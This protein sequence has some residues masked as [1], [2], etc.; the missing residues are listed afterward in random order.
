MKRCLVCGRATCDDL[1]DFGRQPVCH[2]FV[3]TRHEESFYPMALG[4][5]SHCATVQSVQ[6]IPPE[7]LVPHFDW[8]SYN[9]P[10]AH[11]DL[12]VETLCSLPGITNDSTVGGLSYKEDSTLRRFRDRGTQKT[13][14]LDPAADLAIKNPRA[15]IELIQNRIDNLF[16][17]RMRQK[18][19][20]ADILIARHILEHTHD[21]PEF[22]RGVSRMVRP[23]GYLVFEVPDCA[24]A[25]DL[26]DYTT[27]WE[28]HTLYFVEA[29]FRDALQRNGLRIVRFECYRAAYEN[30]LVAIATP[31]GAASA[32]PMQP[33]T[34]ARETERARS[35]ANG[36][37]QRRR[38]LRARLSER[39]SRGKVALLGAGHLAVVYINVFGLADLIDFVIDDNPH[40]RG[41]RMPG[42]RLPIVGSDVLQT[43]DVTLCLTSVSAETEKKV[44]QRHQAFLDGGGVFASIFP[45]ERGAVWNVIAG[46]Q[47]PS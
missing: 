10:E 34:M 29:T 43:E 14:R 20:P 8:I 40:K 42:S 4:Q 7:A 6:P 41:R 9:E 2:H 46:A 5:C 25:F 17:E 45:I 47:Q 12:L 19:G 32:A 27:L 11:L 39:R 30:C 13:W 18:Y 44:V 36:L 31:D 35:F 16:A 24:R 15:G 38:E 33:G 22:L 21:T 26:L 1:I 28:D 37:P 23:G 3:D